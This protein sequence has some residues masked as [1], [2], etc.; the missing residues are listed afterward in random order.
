MRD[1]RQPVAEQHRHDRDLDLVHEAELQQAAEQRAAA[2]EP[3]RLSGLLLE[4]A[5]RLPGSLES[6]APGQSAAASVVENTYDFM[7][8]IPPPPCWRAAS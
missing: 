5:H 2:E 3:D 8:G 1:E 7:P 6:V 4:G